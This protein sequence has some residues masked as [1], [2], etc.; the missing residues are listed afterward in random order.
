M[1]KL[2]VFRDSSLEGLCMT[3]FMRLMNRFVRSSRAGVEFVP[4][5]LGETFYF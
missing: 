1:D 3:P 5:P 2:M 4:V